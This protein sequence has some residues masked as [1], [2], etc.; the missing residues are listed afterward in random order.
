MPARVA[1]ERLVALARAARI[2]TTAAGAALILGL[3]DAQWA[4]IDLATVA[5]LGSWYW[6]HNWGT[7]KGYVHQAAHLHQVQI[8]KGRVDGIAVDI[9]NILKADYG[10][11]TQV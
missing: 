7:P 11:W 4:T 8:D 1:T 3:V 10:Q 9:N 5:G 2:A 6:Q